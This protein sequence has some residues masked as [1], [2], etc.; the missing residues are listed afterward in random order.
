MN[1][2]LKGKNVP[3][4]F[5]SHSSKDE[6]NYKLAHKFVHLLKDV[7]GLQDEEI[8]CSSLPETALDA[9]ED[10]DSVIAGYAKDSLVFISLLT[11]EYLNSRYSMMECG[12]RI[13]VAKTLIPLCCA[14]N[15]DDVTSFPSGRKNIIDAKDVNQL[16]RTLQ[17]IAGNIG[18]DYKASHTS[19][20]VEFSEYIRNITDSKAEINGSK[21]SLST[22]DEGFNPQTFFDEVF[23]KHHLK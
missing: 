16:G 18:R 9:G 20:I 21:S 14:M 4:V 8:F 6:M 12:V 19:Q 23:E 22:D 7:I 2:A 10:I 1:G 5:V 17:R 13:G 3:L 15:I 11:P